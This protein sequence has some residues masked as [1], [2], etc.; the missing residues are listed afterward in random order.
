MSKGY[1]GSLQHNEAIL[2]MFPRGLLDAASNFDNK[3]DKP[4]AISCTQGSILGGLLFRR[5]TCSL[6]R[7]GRL[8]AG[9]GMRLEK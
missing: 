4:E 9:E 3:M 2:Q 8:L 6:E 1:Y 5:T 7:Q